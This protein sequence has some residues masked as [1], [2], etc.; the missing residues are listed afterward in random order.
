MVLALDLSAALVNLGDRDLYGSVV[1]GLDD[2][3]GC[4]ALSGDVT[5]QEIQI[6]KIRE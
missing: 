3:V 6:S 1:L 5:G 4:T 2:A